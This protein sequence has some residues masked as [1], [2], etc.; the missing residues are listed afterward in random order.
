MHNLSKLLNKQII[1]NKQITILVKHTNI[2]VPDLLLCLN[3]FI[4]NPIESKQCDIKIIQIIANAIF[5]LSFTINYTLKCLN[6]THSV[7]NRV[8]IML[9]NS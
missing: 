6:V 5:I 9:S 3:V 1:A 7:V 2:L 4:S 8:V